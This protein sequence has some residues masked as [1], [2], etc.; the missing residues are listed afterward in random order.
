MICAQQMPAKYCTVP[1]IT[2]FDASLCEPFIPFIDRRYSVI[3]CGQMTL[4]SLCRRLDFNTTLPASRVV[5]PPSG[6]RLKVLHISDFH[7]DPRYLTGSEGSLLS[8]DILRIDLTPSIS[9]SGLCP[10]YMCCRKESL[11]ANN[12]STPAF[13]APRFGSFKCDTPYNLAIAAL[14]TIPTLT[15]TVDTGFGKLYPIMLAVRI[16]LIYVPI[17]RLYHLYWRYCGSR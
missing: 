7:I 4:L 1:A 16:V 17:F 13:P 3:D 12:A 15:G 10:G 5:P 11:N 6:K 2:P 8:L 14:E 9:S